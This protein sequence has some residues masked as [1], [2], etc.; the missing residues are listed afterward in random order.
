MGDW[1]SDSTTSDD[2]E[3]DNDDNVFLVANQVGNCI[4]PNF[5]AIK[6]AIA[7][8]PIEPKIIAKIISND[9]PLLSSSSLSFVFGGVL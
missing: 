3:E 5:M 9:S 2:E 6:K 7:M 8:A 4:Y 1:I